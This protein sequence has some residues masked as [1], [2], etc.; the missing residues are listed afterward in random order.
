MIGDLQVL[1]RAILKMFI[2]WSPVVV[3][4]SIV[5]FYC[6]RVDKQ[7]KNKKALRNGNSIRATSKN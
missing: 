6:Y 5:L 1:V 3:I 2:I 7:A 4:I